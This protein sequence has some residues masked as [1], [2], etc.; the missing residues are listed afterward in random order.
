MPYSS[1]EGKDWMCERIWAALEA[2]PARFHEGDR[3]APRLLD[4]GAGSGTYAELL[5]ATRPRRFL[6]HM[7]AI[8][9]YAPYVERFGLRRLYDEVV[10]GDAREIEFPAVDVVVLGDVLEHMPLAAAV[11]VWGKARRAASTAVLAS[12]PVV[13]W[14]QG[15]CEGNPHEAHVETWT[16][17]RVMAELPGIRECWLGGQ[18]GCYQAAP[19]WSAR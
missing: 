16:H 8:E 2:A 9:V 17:E 11:A 7:T 1:G 14:P 5:A 19:P 3:L 10:I 15:E 12:L 13:P 18:I 6:P 4:V